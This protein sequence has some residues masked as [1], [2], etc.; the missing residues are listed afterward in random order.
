MAELI[1]EG[2]RP[3]ERWQRKLAAGNPVVLGKDEPGWPV[4]WER[5]ISRRHL[6][7]VYEHDQLSVKKLPE[8]RNPVFFHGRLADDFRMRSGDCFVIGET[9]FTFHADR[10]SSPQRARLAQE[11]SIGAEQL[12]NIPFRDAPHR[13]DVLGRLS[14]VIS[15]LADRNELYVQTVNLLLEGIRRANAIA[16]VE[17]APDGD[18]A[19][20]KTLYADHRLTTGAEVQPS[21]RLVREA[22]QNLTKS[23]VHVW[24]PGE[25]AAEQ[26]FTMRS[27]FDWA[28]CTPLHGESCQRLGLYVMGQ[29]APEAARFDRASPAGTDLDEDVKF[30]E[31]V[32]TILSSL[33][34]VK[35]L[36]HRQNVL[37]HFFSP[38]VLPLLTSHDSQET[39]QP[40]ETD[41]TVMFCDLRGFSSKVEGAGEALLRI[42]ERVS[43]ALGVMSHCILEHSGAVADFL[44]D[45]AMGFWG[46]PLRGG[47][48]ATQA[49]LA[50]L[51]IRETFDTLSRQRG[52]PLAGFMAG[53]GIATGHAVAGQI[54]SQDQAKVT[55]FGPCVNLASRLEGLTKTLRVP[56]LLDEATANVAKERIPRS[57]GRLRKLARVKPQGLK[58][59]VMVSEL[60]PPVER[61]SCLSDEDIAHYEAGLAEFL[62][63]DWAAAYERLHRVP[64]EDRGKDLLMSFILKHDHTPPPNWDGVI[65]IEQK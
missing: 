33:L 4:P 34:E 1:A 26:L 47:D 40:R 8:G 14:K 6:E 51:G 39:L 31:L 59:P 45:A 57:A 30:A 37:S 64:A 12:Q 50:A 35:E 62:R 46:W 5:W 32:A 48:D 20:V 49:C 13:I 42:L 63:G 61:D 36:Q 21:R 16:V 38:R 56:V 24:S 23:V 27:K 17:V 18:R 25:E 28:F 65:A 15:G 22:I 54:G 44:G 7:L 2:A 11:Y 55:V 53:V 19:E 60:L 10:E 52:H 9:V 43:Q 41:I 58:T 29:S 3:G